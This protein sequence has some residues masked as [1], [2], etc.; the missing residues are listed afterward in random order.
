M[1][2]CWRVV[3]R[4][5]GRWFF[6]VVPVRWFG[7]LGLDPVR[8]VG[9]LE[10]ALGLALHKAGQA[11]VVVVWLWPLGRDALAVEV[12]GVSPAA[13]PGAFQAEEV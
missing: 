2:E 12:S 9:S 7:R 6:E 10:E 13:V 11:G 5:P 4:A 3:E 8:S 1:D